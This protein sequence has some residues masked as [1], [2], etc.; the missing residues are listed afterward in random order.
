MKIRPRLSL[1]RFALPIFVLLSLV[2]SSA[3]L[4]RLEPAGAQ[5]VEVRISELNCDSNP[6]MLVIINDGNQELSMTGWNLQSDPVA[7]QSIELDAQGTLSAGESLLV[8]AGP[9]A[10]AA[11]KFSTQ[12]VFRDGDPTDFAQLASDA[13]E[14]LLKVNCSGAAQPTTA[15][16]AVAGAAATPVA[17]AV[18]V[19]GGP[20]AVGAG[21]TLPIVM[22]VAGTWLVTAGLSVF[23]LSWLRRSSGTDEPD[24]SPV[25][26]LLAD[27]WLHERERARAPV[28]A[29]RRVAALMVAAHP[30][31]K[32]ERN[33]AQAARLDH[34]LALV[35]IG[36]AVVAILVFLL[37]DGEGKRE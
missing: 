10:T 17:G 5:G 34:Y 23:S 29:S 6:E 11:V 27:R 25:A 28:E 3:L 4:I 24:P 15:T 32:P 19:G 18:P 31:A 7:E 14:V 9:S 2:A 1:F 21:V 22:I 16:P 8:E 26:P 13:G 30:T 33:S 20:L 35:A 37:Q 12:F 36:A